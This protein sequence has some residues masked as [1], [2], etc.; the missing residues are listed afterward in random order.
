MMNIVDTNYLLLVK[1]IFLYGIDVLNLTFLLPT[2][3]NVFFLD[4]R[5]QTVLNYF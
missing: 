4:F 5:D 1:L 2:L 3:R